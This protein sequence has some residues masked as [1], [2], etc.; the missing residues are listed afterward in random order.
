MADLVPQDGRVHVKPST[1][2]ND[3]TAVAP[4]EERGRQNCTISAF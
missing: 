4:V 3:G 2:D 1:N